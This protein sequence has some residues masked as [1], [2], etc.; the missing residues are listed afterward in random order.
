MSYQS[1]DWKRAV[2][3]HGHVCPGLATGYRVS[4]A[5]LRELASLR[6]ADEEVVAIVET[7]SCGVDA[8][9][10]LT[11]CTFGKGNLIFHDFGKHVFTFACRDSR[12]GVRISVKPRS[13]LEPA[14]MHAL[15]EKVS[16]GTASK[17]EQERFQQYHARMIERILQAPEEELLSIREMSL[18]IPL[19]ARIFRSVECAYCGEPVMEPRARIRDGKFACIPCSNRY[20]LQHFIVRDA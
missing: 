12:K 13:W 10:A 15:R 4:L 14:D 11:G 1:N 19:R 9:Q 7:D 5:G 8:V 18:E 16:G 6:S 3:F 17:P 20:M 2:E